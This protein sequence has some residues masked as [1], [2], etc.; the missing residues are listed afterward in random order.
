MIIYAKCTVLFRVICADFFL[1][2]MEKL[3]EV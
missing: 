1:N 3:S 2:T